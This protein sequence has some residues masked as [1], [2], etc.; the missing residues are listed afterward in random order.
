[1]PSVYSGSCPSMALYFLNF[2]S[3]PVPSLLLSI[4]V[5]LTFSACATKERSIDSKQAA[6]PTPAAAANAPPLA[7]AEKAQVKR[8][9]SGTF[10]QY[11]FT[12]RRAGREVEA[13]FAPVRL[14]WNDSLVVAAAREVL[15]AAYDDRSENFPRPAVWQYGGAEA[16]AIKLEAEKFEYVFLPLKEEGRDGVKQVRTIVVWQLAKGTIR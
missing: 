11:K 4:T 15:V 14:P 13:T 16:R 9:G 3:K 1:M 5:F 10:N 6:S 12:Y 8:T 7:D 2:V